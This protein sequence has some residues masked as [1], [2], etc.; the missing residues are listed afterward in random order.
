MAHFKAV[1]PGTRVVPGTIAQVREPLLPQPPPARPAE[2]R[3]WAPPQRPLRAGRSEAL[4]SIVGLKPSQFNLG[5]QIPP[6]LLAVTAVPGRLR[7]NIFE[8]LPGRKVVLEKEGTNPT[9]VSF[10][11]AYGNNGRQYVDTNGYSLRV[12]NVDFNSQYSLRVEN[13]GQGMYQLVGRPRDGANPAVVLATG[14]IDDQGRPVAL[15]L[16]P[17]WTVRRRMLGDPPKFLGHVYLYH[18]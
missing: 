9:T 16:E 4:P 17:G 1:A 14:R 11:A 13:N 8:Q 5:E 2:A 6:E 10:K 3:P 7:L 12:G 18:D 15:N